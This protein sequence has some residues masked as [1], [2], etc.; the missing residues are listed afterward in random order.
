MRRVV[1][2]LRSPALVQDYLNELPYNRELD[3]P[4]LRT[5]RGVVT[6]G[7]AHCLEAAL[8]AATVLEVH[9]LPPLV[10]SLES[11]DLLDHVLFVYRGERGWGSVARSRDPGLH[12]R[13]PVFRGLRELALSYVDPYVDLTACLKGYGAYDLR[14]LGSYDWRHSMRNVWR[15]EEELR[16]LR[17]RP[18]RVGTARRDRLRARFRALQEQH[19]GAK[20]VDFPGRRRWSELP[21]EW[22]AAIAKCPPGGGQPCGADGPAR[23]LAQ[24]DG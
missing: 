7:T 1:R 19:P 24:V 11:V 23:R 18:L 13:L 14:W 15:V 17:H 16:R 4:T 22:R 9:G 3:R 8:F 2:R 6:H 21:A 10:M 20:P 12:G 5:L